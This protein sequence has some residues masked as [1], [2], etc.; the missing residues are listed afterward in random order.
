MDS[1]CYACHFDTEIKFLKTNTHKPVI[2]A[3]CYSCHKS[4]GAPMKKLLPIEANDPKLCID[5]HGEL[6]KEVGGGSNHA[7]FKKG[8]LRLNTPDFTT[9][10]RKLNCSIL[11][12]FLICQGS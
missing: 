12:I 1:V 7:F 3:K 5:C 4:H 8:K 10:C 9:P 6:M 2:E 11:E